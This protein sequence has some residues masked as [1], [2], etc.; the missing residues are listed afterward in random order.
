[1]CVCVYGAPVQVFMYQL[2]DAPGEED[3]AL[4]PP[5]FASMYTSVYIY[6]EYRGPIY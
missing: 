3:L 1:M 6:Q 2:Y 4:P 5:P